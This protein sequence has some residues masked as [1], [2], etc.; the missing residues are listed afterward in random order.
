MSFELLLL[1]LANAI[2]TY[3]GLEDPVFF[4]K[5]KFNVSAIRRGEYYRLITSGFLHGSWTHFIFNMLTLYFFYPPL[6]QW[7]GTGGA[8]AIYFAGLILG[9]LTAYYFHKDHPWYSAIGA[10]GA[11]NAVVFASI[12]FNPDA[13]IIIFPIPIPIPAILYAVGYL[14][15]TTFGMSRQ[16]GIIGHEAHF[17]GAAAGILTA[18]LLEPAL[19][20]ART[21]MLLVLILVIVAGFFFAKQK[22]L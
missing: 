19:L 2:F 5:Y 14:L 15:Y 8:L 13:S 10:S 12:L 22:K 21:G 6:K 1:I 16:S 20:K 18:V 9:N 11:V 7:V 17:G 3:K 4:D